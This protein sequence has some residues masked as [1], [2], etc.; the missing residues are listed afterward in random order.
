MSDF[1]RS[2]IQDPKKLCGELKRQ[3][4]AEKAM[5]WENSAKDIIRKGTES[6]SGSPDTGQLLNSIYTETHDNGFIGV[7][8]A[9][10]AKYL[11]FGTEK[12]W[13]P[14]YSESGVPILAG[15]GRRVLKLSKDEMSAIGGLMVASPELAFMRRSLAKL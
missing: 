9:S 6:G 7:S 14:F 4:I 10:H 5:E 13:V 11:E 3:F 15:W 8:S 2:T 1:V 12:H